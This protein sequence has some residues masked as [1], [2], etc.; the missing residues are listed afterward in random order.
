[1]KDTA[2]PMPPS[3]DTPATAAEIGKLQA[4]IDAGMPKGTCGSTPPADAGGV[5]DTGPS[6]TGP[7]PYDVPA[8]CSS[9]QK[10][11]L[12]DSGSS[13]M[14]PG[15]ACITCHKTHP[16]APRF[17]A[18][19]TVFPTAH[20]PDDCV[21]RVTGA[22]VVLTGADGKS[23]TLTVNS[24]SGNFNYTGTLALPYKAK[25]VVGGKSRA[26]SA[27][28]TNG[29]CNSCHTQTGASGAPGRIIVP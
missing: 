22:T 1:M 13:M 23:V 6:D 28:Q 25:V 4:W 29:D 17:T 12:G 18:A 20:E 3:P 27:S 21:S 10:W 9:G 8:K 2:S 26:M 19:G 5:A 24:N 7:N 11:L 15:K 16:G 14:H